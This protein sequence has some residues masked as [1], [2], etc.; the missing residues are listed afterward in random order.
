MILIALLVFVLVLAVARNG[1]FGPVVAAATRDGVRWGGIVGLAGFVLGFIGPMIVVPEANQ[2]P[3]LGLFITGP[4]GA[5]VGF[6]YG[7]IASLL[8]GDRYDA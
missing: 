3:M 6:V 7:V 2:G 5:V 8:R 1:S 4:G